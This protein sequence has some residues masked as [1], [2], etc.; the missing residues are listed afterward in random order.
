MSILINQPN[1]HHTNVL[2]SLAKQPRHSIRKRAAFFG[3]EQS[4]SE[5]YGKGRRER[6]SELVS[7]YPRVVSHEDFEEQAPHLE[8]IEVVFTTWSIPR[9]TPERLDKLPSLRAVY[10]AGGSVHHF[11]RPLLERNITVVSA[12]QAN[13]VPVAEFTLGQILLATKGYFRNSTE[14]TTSSA[15]YKGFRGR[16]NFGECIAILGA[17]AIGGRV[18]QLLRAFQLSVIVFDPFLSDRNAGELGVEKVSLEEAFQ[19]GYVVSNH[20][21][22]RPE[23][24]CMLQGAHFSKMRTDA[25][26][27]NTGRGATVD[28]PGMISVLQSR[29]DITALLD[30]TFPEP[31]PDGS[32]LYTLSN[33]HLTSH[34]AGS[35]GDEIVR[36]ADYC[37]DDFIAAENNDPQRYTVSSSMLET[38]A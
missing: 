17:G 21:A 10:Y 15:C 2:R 1:G 27:I 16:G 36:M 26:F 29:P 38:M 28:E 18:I 32:P 30:V 9:M 25:T 23:T 11:A 24:Q 31:P 12:W 22:N 6:L 8:D 37:I 5:V 35:I 4:I 13:A 3:N 34:I 7:L 20:L 14:Y 33:V 19:R